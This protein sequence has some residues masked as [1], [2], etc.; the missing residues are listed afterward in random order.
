MPVASEFEAI[1]G[2]HVID[3]WFPRSL[4]RECGGFLCDFD[5][6]WKPCG[7]NEK[8]LEFQARHTWFAAEAS[9]IYPK[10][11]RLREA[12]EHGFSYLRGPLWDEVSGG[13]FSLLDRAGKPIEQHTKHTH[14]FAYAILAC[15]AVYRAT[16][17]EAALQLARD[18]FNWIYR[19]AHDSEYGGYFAALRRDGTIIRDDTF[20]GRIPIDTPLGCKDISVHSGLLETFTSLYQ[21][22]PDARVGDQLAEIVDIVCN[23]MTLPVGAHHQYCLSNWTPVPHLTRFGHQIYN[24]FRLLK[25]AHLLDGKKEILSV[26]RALTNYALRYGWDKQRGGFYFAGPGLGPSRLQGQNLM[27]QKKLSWVQ[28]GALKALLAVHRI[29]L[30]EECY[31][32]WFKMQWR[33]IQDELIDHSCRGFYTAGLDALPWYQRRKPSLAPAY[34]TRKGSNWK[35]SSHDGLSLLYCASS[36]NNPG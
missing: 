15:V 5:Y 4:D 2:A 36:L 27:V 17:N 24:A 6:R 12:V 10:D 16:G 8:L 32:Q 31:L 34:L 21:T 28:V 33:Y 9:K 29:A 7:P 22:W 30:D 11:E 14:G 3:V 18:G 35:D 26:A 1:L 25:A 23:R 20:V 13:W 19:Y